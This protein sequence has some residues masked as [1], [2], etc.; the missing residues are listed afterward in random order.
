MKKGTHRIESVRTFAALMK[1]EKECVRIYPC[2]HV[3]CTH[4]INIEVDLSVRYYFSGWAFRLTRFIFPNAFE[5]FRKMFSLHCVCCFG[6]NVCVFFVVLLN[7]SSLYTAIHTQPDRIWLVK[8]MNE[9]QWI[10]TENCY[11]NMI[12]FTARIN[13]HTADFDASDEQFLH[14][15]SFQLAFQKHCMSIRLYWAF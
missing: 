15:I 10:C 2:V 13:F 12:M 6:R 3:Q 4:N 14:S 7:S 1:R 8:E 5:I 11:S 9:N